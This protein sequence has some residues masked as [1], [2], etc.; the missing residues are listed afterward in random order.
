MHAAGIICVQSLYSK[1][2][3]EISV[4]KRLHELNMVPVLPDIRRKGGSP[5]TDD[6]L[7]NESLSY[8]GCQNK[9]FENSYQKENIVSSTLPR[10]RRSE[11]LVHLYAGTIPGGSLPK[12]LKSITPFTTWHSDPTTNSQFNACTFDEM[13]AVSV[14]SPFDPSLNGLENSKLNKGLRFN[15]TQS[16]LDLRKEEFNC[17]DKLYSVPVKG[18]NYLTTNQIV[19]RHCAPLFGARRALSMDELYGYL[20]HEK[21]IFPIHILYGESQSS[22]ARNSR[23]SLASSDDLQKYRDIA[24]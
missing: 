18:I 17:R 9:G 8:A 16:L 11:R 6:P 1:W 10:A 22:L 14:R 12:R 21:P 5:S 24:L 13:F 3:E 19:H 2:K 7:K 23:R 20:R 4:N 15:R